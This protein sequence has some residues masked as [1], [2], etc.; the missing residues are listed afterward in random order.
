MFSVALASYMFLVLQVSFVNKA[1]TF[2][3]GPHVD[4]V[5]N[6]ITEYVASFLNKKGWRANKEEHEVKRHLWIFINMLVENP[7]FSSPT[8]EALVGP[9]G[10]LES[11]KLSDLFMDQGM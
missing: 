6:Q 4:Y 9:L 10:S 2:V 5:S 11:F 8:K 3:G 1:T 7:T